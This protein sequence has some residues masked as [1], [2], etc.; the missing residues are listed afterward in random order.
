[1]AQQLILFSIGPVQEFIAS[2]RRSRDLWFGSW[3]MSELAKAAAQQIA[4][5]VPGNGQSDDSPGLIFP[6]PTK[7]D[8]LAAN[9]RFNAP[10]KIIVLIDGDPEPLAT[11]V[12]QAISDRL[13]AIW[14][15]AYGEITGALIDHERAEKQRDD[16]VELAWVALPLAAPE[17]YAATRARLEALMAARK[18]TRTFGPVTWGGTQPKS[19]LDGQ[20]EAVIDDSVYKGGPNKLSELELFYQ[21]GVRPGERLCGI[22]LLKRHGLRSEGGD[23]GRFFSTS[24]VAALPLLEH[25]TDASAVAAYIKILRSFGVREGDLGNVPGNPHVAFQR[26]DGRLLFADRLHEYIKDTNRLLEAQKALQTF[27]QA[28]AGKQLPNQYYALLHADGDGM[29]EAID[30]QQQIGAHRRLSQDLAK[31]AGRVR[32]IVTA[33]KGSLVYAGGD[34]VLAFVPLHTVLGCARTLADRFAEAMDGFTYTREGET[35][36]PTLS[37]GVVIAHHLD[38]L[39]DSLDAVRKAERAAKQLPGKNALAITLL[40]RSGEPRTLCGAWNEQTILGPLDQRLA[41]FVR[42]HLEQRIPDGLAY[43]WHVL[44]RRLS[45]PPETRPLADDEQNLRQQ[46]KEASGYEAQRILE[47]KRAQSGSLVLAQEEL[48]VLGTLASE[49]PLMQLA[50]ELVVARAL[51]DAL[52]LVP[53]AMREQLAGIGETL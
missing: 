7:A 19:S 37:V 17:H 4:Q 11:A 42:L 34:D 5:A 16:L 53:S 43:E 47:R 12:R 44:G 27:L 28:A 20:R 24:H 36:R 22:G 8:D 25:I 51:A 6:F 30:A 52:Q 45:A 31:F 32:E 21:Y 26:Y 13:N 48:E 35:M 39:S 23:T 49:L 18:A 46:L 15:D 3:L 38:H 2:A 10:N 40:K 50:D 1:M 29:G 9:S 14:D 41:H 33:F